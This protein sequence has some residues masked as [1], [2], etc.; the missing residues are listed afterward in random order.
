MKRQRLYKRGMGGPP[1]FLRSVGILPTSF[2]FRTSSACRGVAQFGSAPRSKATRA[3]ASQHFPQGPE[4]GLAYRLA[5]AERRQSRRP[6]GISTC[7]PIITG[8][9]ISR[10]LFNCRG[11]AQPGSAPRSGRGGRG[12]ESRRPDQKASPSGGFFGAGMKNPR[13]KLESS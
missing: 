11:V 7:P 4:E 12:F 8:I 13:S 3:L 10:A 1:V 9:S 5:G 6:V 2:F